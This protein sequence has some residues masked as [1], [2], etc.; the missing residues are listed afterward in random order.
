MRRQG[1]EVPGESRPPER[2][3]PGTGQLGAR[4]GRPHRPFGGRAAAAAA[5]CSGCRPRLR[6][7]ARSI[8]AGSAAQSRSE[9][10]AS[11]ASSVAHT[12]GRRG[13]AIRPL[14]PLS[15]PPPA[16][17]GVRLRSRPEFRQAAGGSG[18]SA[19]RRLRAR[20]PFAPGSARACRGVSGHLPA[21]A[22]RGRRGL[23]RRR[24][25]SG[26]GERT[27]FVKGLW[28]APFAGRSGN[29]R[30]QRRRAPGGWGCPGASASVPRT[31]PGARG[32]PC[33]GGHGRS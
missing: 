28:S 18:R 3:V 33:G 12:T 32:R 9:P 5:S 13:A 26:R 21:R 14:G 29:P 23:A 11:P 30:L 2:R 4:T 31:A 16:P 10:G 17:P 22:R 1:G 25:R 20:R 19:W 15:P 24:G 27:N 6:R 7:T 8:P